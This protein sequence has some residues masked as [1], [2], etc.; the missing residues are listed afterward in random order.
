MLYRV[1]SQ[2]LHWTK[3]ST[4]ARLLGNERVLVAILGVGLLGSIFRVLSS[5][6]QAPVKF[7]SFA[8]LFVVLVVLTW[9]YTEPL[10][11]E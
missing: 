5:S 10:T 7:L 4:I 8:L 3:H 1:I 2:L 11:D 9:N 6:M